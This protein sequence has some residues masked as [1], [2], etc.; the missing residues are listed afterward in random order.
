MCSDRDSA[1]PVGGGPAPPVGEWLT[2]ASTAPDGTPLAA[3]AAHPQAPTG[4]GVVVLP[5]LRGLC[6]FYRQLAVC[7]AEH[8]HTAVAIDYYGRTAGFG[9]RGDD[10]RFME[11][12]A[13][14]SRAAI[15]GDLGAGIAWL[16][17]PAGG[18]CRAV[19]TLGFC[20]GGRAS[21]LAS[22]SHPGLAGTI[23]FYGAPGSTGPYQ[24]PGPT[25][26]ADRL[27]APVLALMGGADDGIPP[28]EV[29]AFDAALA[30]AGVQHEVV[31]Y[32]AAPHGFFDVKH[33]QFAEASADAWQRALQFIHRHR[34]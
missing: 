5:D 30:A 33:A 8:G 20:M 26:L 11:H 9:E 27:T 16:R 6:R 28:S 4:T 12:A 31:V 34:H 17:A 22:T 14:L 24:D 3:F 13:R 25:Q 29:K 1:P 7:L 15:Q 23:G 18:G 21:F 2:L 32:P 19:F 10:F